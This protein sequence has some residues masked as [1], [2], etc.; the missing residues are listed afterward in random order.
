MGLPPATH[1]T[2]YVPAGSEVPLEPE[3]GCASTKHCWES[4]ALLRDSILWQLQDR[5]YEALGESAWNEDIPIFVSSNAK[6][7][8]DYARVIFNWLRDVY[9][10]DR[11]GCGGGSSSSSA[12]APGPS[13]K[14]PSPGPCLLLEIG[15]GHGRFTCLLLRSLLRFQPFFEQLGMPPRPFVL[16]FTDVAS[17]NVEACRQHPDLRPFVEDGWLDFAVLDA[18]DPPSTEELRQL[19][20]RHGCVE[21]LGGEVPTAL[22]CNYVLDTLAQEALQFSS[23]PRMVRRGRLSIFSQQDPLE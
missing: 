17:Q 14:R 5:Y 9:A 12:P 4:K 2:V 20:S 19:A 1:G 10:C 3:E 23:N 13:P 6:L 21:S 7:A 11:L 16:I 15:A 18:N 22:I 8:Q